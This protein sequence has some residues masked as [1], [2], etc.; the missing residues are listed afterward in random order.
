MKKHFIFAILVAVSLIFTL[1][2]CEWFNTEEPHECESA[3][4]ECGECLD[5][6]CTEEAC[7]DKCAGHH[8]C[9]SAC[10]ECGKCLDAE[11]GE[12][13]CAD[14]CSCHNKE[15]LCPECGGCIDN[16]CTYDGC[17]V[18]CSCERFVNIEEELADLLSHHLCIHKV[19]IDPHVFNVERKIDIIKDSGQA[20]LVTFEEVNTYYV[21]AYYFGDHQYQYHDSQLRDTGDFYCPLNY[22]FLRFNSAEEIEKTYNN[23]DLKGAFVVWEVLSV[24]DI[25]SDDDNAPKFVMYDKLTLGEDGINVPDMP[26]ERFIYI[27]GYH[28]NVGT[29]TVY[30]ST[31]IRQHYKEQV[32]FPCGNVNG[33]DY[34]TFYVYAFYYNDIKKDFGK[35]YDAMS[36]VMKTDIYYKTDVYGN[37]F[38]YYLIKVEDF[39]EILKEE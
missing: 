18:K 16:I 35:Y 20:L 1:T 31:G 23:R 21:G 3:C 19:D 32:T 36:S 26:D 38:N 30:Y 14:K 22:V 7:A 11:C 24:S 17:D 15:S 10:S 8:K 5:I 34:L 6:E 27:N 39:V 2:S 33:E 9:E 12:E 25:L 4:V 37:M 29:D 13:A 28:T